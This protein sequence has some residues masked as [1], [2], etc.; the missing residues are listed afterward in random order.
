LQ[1]KNYLPDI[2][3]ISVFSSAIKTR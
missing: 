3:L 1:T 2:Y